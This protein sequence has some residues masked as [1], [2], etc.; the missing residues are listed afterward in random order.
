MNAYAALATFVLDFLEL[1]IEYIVLV[2]AAA[3]GATAAG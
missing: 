3:T 1:G 2:A